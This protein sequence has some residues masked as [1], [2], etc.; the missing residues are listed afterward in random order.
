MAGGGGKGKGSALNINLTPMID[1][2]MLLVIFFLL[3]TEIASS[4]FIQLKLPKP[5]E[6]M[7]RERSSA[8]RAVINVIPYS[9]ADI[10]AGIG[11]LEKAMKYQLEP[12][13]YEN[14][15]LLNL[16]PEL[17]RRK[18]LSDKPDDFTVVIRSDQRIDYTEVEPLFPC[19][20]DAG[21]IKVQLS[22]WRKGG[23]D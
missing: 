1:C 9:D 8:N 15:T 19:I 18:A 23:G 2:T 22:A 3:T 12:Y 16:I 5:W 21:I 14:R 10:K 13:E 20:Q 4:N 17:R 7:A 6:S 11:K